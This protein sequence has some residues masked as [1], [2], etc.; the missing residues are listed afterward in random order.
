MAAVALFEFPC[1][2]LCAALGKFFRFVRPLNTRIV[3]FN[4]MYLV[5]DKKR[6]LPVWGG[7]AGWPFP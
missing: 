4:R 7:I 5:V 2:V 3:L 6:P 1:P